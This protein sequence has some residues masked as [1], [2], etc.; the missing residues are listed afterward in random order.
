MVVN[1]IKDVK[2]INWILILMAFTMLFMD[3]NFYHNFQ[4]K[5]TSHYSHELRVGATF[6]YLGPN[7]TAVFYAQNTIIVVC[8]LMADKNVWHKLLFGLTVGFNYFCLMFLYSRGGYLATL[9]SLM[10]YGLIK[11]RFILIALTVVLLFWRTF[12]PIS[13]Q[14]RIDMSQTEKGTDHSIAARYEMWDQA[15]YAIQR[16]PI[17]GVGYGGTPFLNITTD[18]DHYRKTLH[19]GHLELLLELGVVGAIIFA[20]FY[21]MCVHYGWRLF[22]TSTDPLLKGLGLG[23]IGSV[24]A[25]LAGNIAGS[26]L[27]YFNVSGF[28][29]VNL[30]L[31]VR[32]LE[33]VKAN[34]E[35]A[36]PEAESKERVVGKELQP[37]SAV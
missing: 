20:V 21:G 11:N 3:R 37:I 31:V 33:I 30:G 2:Y 13:V 12:I 23:F 19:N 36:E 7:E 6:S 22:R 14:Q 4:G 26:Y 32:S 5:D 25:V 29:W 34:K 10:F 9:V 35:G 27:F 18:K 16:N 8:I 1:N 17:T 24:L 28:F 15:I